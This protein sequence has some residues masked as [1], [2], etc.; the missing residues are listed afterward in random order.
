MTSIFEE[1]QQKYKIQKHINAS[2][3]SFKFML[4]KFR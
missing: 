2:L 1:K 4:A 3:T